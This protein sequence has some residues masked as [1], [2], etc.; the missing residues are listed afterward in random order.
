MIPQI[1]KALSSGF[2]S[3]QIIK[4]L[5]KKFPQHANKI[6]NALAAGF[7]VDQVVKYLGG[8]RKELNKMSAESNEDE[9]M[10]P[11]SKTLNKD[12]KGQENRAKNAT[13]AGVSAVSAPMAATA[14][15]RALPQNLLRLGQNTPQLQQTIQQTLQPP[16][17]PGPNSPGVQVL[18]PKGP[19]PSPNSPMQQPQQ[20]PINPL[21]PLQGSPTSQPPINSPTIPQPPQTIQPQRDIKKSVDIIKST[22]QEATVKNLLEGGLSPSAIKDTLG[23]ILGK[24][25]L[26]ELEKE[27]G[28]IEQAIED[29][30]QTTKEQPQEQPQMESAS[31]QL[32]AIQPQ[33]QR[34]QPEQ[35]QLEA[36]KPI[37][38]S[39]L[40]QK[41]ETVSTPQGIGEVKE[42]RNG[43]AIV[44]VDGKLHK[45]DESELIQSP[46]PKK[47]LADLFD[48][49]KSGIE[50]ETGNEISKNVEWAGY[51]PIKNVLAYKPW[52]GGGK[53]YTYSDI[54]PEDVAELQSI[55]AQRKTSGQNY[56]GIWEKDSKSPIGN[57]MHALITRLQKERG[58]KGN[59]YLNKFETIYDPLEPAKN[60]SKEKYKNEQK[61][62]KT[63]QQQ[64]G[65]STITSR[66]KSNEAKKKKETGLKSLL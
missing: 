27:T 43:K 66:S 52:M 55:L 59:E 36:E 7:T 39:K 9:G 48:D 32:D 19:S 46:I 33:T 10:T 62:K 22:G 4:Y 28:G 21:Q 24:K 17:G 64:S 30:A 25:K 40:I 37:E 49:L 20:P 35:I 2:T 53:I 63:G 15:S 31:Q 38:E 42:I 65:I 5:L 61:L 18:N 23:V 1:S 12:I 6:N 41:S 34:M 57:R 58:G 13:M 54:S 14:L 11:Y 8:G 3:S 50:Q 60:A 47:D 26:K 45:V 51:D 29:Y 16:M 56:I 44:A